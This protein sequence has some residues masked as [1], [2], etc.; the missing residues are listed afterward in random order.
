M[1]LLVTRPQPEAERTAAT[2]RAAG[3]AVDVAALLRIESIPAELGSGPWSA[4]AVTSANTLRALDK[5]PRRAALLSLRLFA[6]GRRTAAAARMAGF[7]DVESAGGN[8]EDLAQRLRA[9]A[10]EEP[11]GRDPL[12]YLAGEDRSGDLAGALA[13]AGQNVATVVVYRA[14]KADKFPPSIAAALGSGQIE[15]VLHFSRRSAQAYIECARAGGTLA[16]ALAPIQFCLSGQ[17]AEP[18]A[19]AGANRT[20]IAARPEESAL[21]ALVEEGA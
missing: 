20:R 4:L 7:R 17:I 11:A 14:V 19:A 12:L 18:L 5:H 21:V 8:V 10:Q 1:R 16:Q 2:L 15:G 6:V 3:H 13:A 9:W